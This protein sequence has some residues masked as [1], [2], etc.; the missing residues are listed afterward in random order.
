MRVPSR[1]SEEP[2]T[3][4]EV[5]ENPEPQAEGTAKYWILDFLVGGVLGGIFG[6]SVESDWTGFIS[7]FIVLGAAWTL[8]DVI[9][10][11]RTGRKPWE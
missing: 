6:V 10:F 1:V 9:K 2:E 7:G 11:R 8:V 3:S 5:C 4:S